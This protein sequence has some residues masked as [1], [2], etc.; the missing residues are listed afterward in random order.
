LYFDKTIP[1]LPGDFLREDDS[2]TICMQKL[3]HQ[4]LGLRI[5]AFD[6]AH[7]V[8]AGFFACTSAI[9]SIIF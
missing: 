6:A 2:E 5:L 4:L 8:A 3:P 1:G 7:I 9:T